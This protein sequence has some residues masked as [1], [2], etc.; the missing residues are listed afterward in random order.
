MKLSC[1]K[2]L[3][4]TYLS[5]SSVA[6]VTPNWWTKQAGIE[7]ANES[8]LNNLL[9]GEGKTKFIVID[10]YWE[11]CPDC[12]HILEE[13]NKIVNNGYSKFNGEVIFTQIEGKRNFDTIAVNYD[14]NW[15]PTLIILAP[16]TYGTVY[17]RFPTS[18]GETQD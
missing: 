15:Y 6:K 7:I 16:H 17:Q 1:F 13:W 9:I 4:L 18:L 2:F 14:I 3:L 10:F 5:I 12:E 11:K 8:L